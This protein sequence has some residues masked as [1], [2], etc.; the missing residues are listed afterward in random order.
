M[1]DEIKRH[2]ELS[3]LTDHKESIYE[4]TRDLAGIA[5]QFKEDTKEDTEPPN[6]VLSAISLMYQSEIGG[7]V[8]DISKIA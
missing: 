7:D 8:D 6:A 3:E 2:A 1:K 5:K 4:M